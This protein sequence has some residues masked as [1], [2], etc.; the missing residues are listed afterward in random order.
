MKLSLQDKIALIY[1]LAGSQRRAAD[2]IGISHQR[3]G[4]ILRTGYDGGYRHDSRALTD[5]VL[6][7]AVNHAF[8]IHSDVTRLQAREHGLP[9]DPRFPVFYER[10]PLPDGTPGDRV[11]A[12]H[13]HWLSDTLRNSWVASMQQSGRFYSASVSSMVD[14]VVYSRR[15]VEFSKDKYRAPDG[16]TS[17]DRAISQNVTRGTIFTKYVPMDPRYISPHELI[18]GLNMMLYNKHAPA[19][20]SPGTALATSV[21]L[22]VDTRKTNQDGT[23]KDAVFRAA[24]PVTAKPRKARRN[25]GRSS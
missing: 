23:S 9:F 4:R 25:K 21:L 19:V 12:L 18:N 17:I 8:K 24:H 3:V 16:T 1:T 10:K 15:A 11:V 14:L 5:P 20:A 13:T 2:L 6:I 22:Q 7:G